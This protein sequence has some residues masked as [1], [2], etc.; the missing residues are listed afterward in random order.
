M[1]GCAS[2]LPKTLPPTNRQVTNRYPFLHI[3]AERSPLS[4][5]SLPWLLFAI[6]PCNLF[7]LFPFL[8]VRLS[9][10]MPLPP[11]RC[12]SENRPRPNHTKHGHNTTQVGNGRASLPVRRTHLT[13][14]VDALEQV[15]Q[16][17]LTNQHFILCACARSPLA[18]TLVEACAH[19]NKECAGAASNLT[20]VFACLR[21]HNGT[22]CCSCSL[23]QM[24]ALL[25]KKSGRQ[26][27]SHHMRAPTPFACSYQNR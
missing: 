21:I 8:S 20:P 9:L 22:A 4:V 13:S 3:C 24:R 16:C 1:T 15:W 12:K 10:H 27:C 7:S 14:Q 25:W 5:H 26:V 6:V 11:R 23:V 17:S 2:S 18:C 19:T